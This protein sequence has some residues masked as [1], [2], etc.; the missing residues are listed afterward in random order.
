LSSFRFFSFFLINEGK[1]LSLSHINKSL[2]FIFSSLKK[3][4]LSLLPQSLKPPRKSEAIISNANSYFS[5][6][7]LTVEKGK[8]ISISISSK[9]LK[10]GVSL[11]VS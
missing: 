10:F 3:I 2:L 4:I 9:N 6:L 7:N 5:F 11:N 8:P 1:T